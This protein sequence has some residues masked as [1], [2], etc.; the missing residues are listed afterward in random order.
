MAEVILDKIAGT[1]I[2]QVVATEDLKNG[3]WLTL[4]LLDT[5]GER[6]LAT[7]AAK[8]EEADVFLAT[9][10]VKYDPNADQSKF[11]TKAGT[12]GRAYHMVSGDVV[13]VTKDL[14]AKGAKKGDSLTIGENGLGFKKAEGRGIAQIIGEENMGYF[15]DMFVIAIR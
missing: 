15:G 8:E 2:E 9:E 12:T 4:G 7:K 14:V 10:F 6:R 3:Q 11:E 5:D 1:H 13:S